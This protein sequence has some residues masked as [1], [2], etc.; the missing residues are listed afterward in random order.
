MLFAKRYQEATTFLTDIQQPIG[1]DNAKVELDNMLFLWP[2]HRLAKGQS[3]QINDNSYAGAVWR[4]NG[5]NKNEEKTL[6]FAMVM[7]EH[8]S[9]YFSSLFTQDIQGEGRMAIELLVND[10]RAAANANQNNPYMITSMDGDDSMIH[11]VK[12]IWEQQEQ[13][14]ANSPVFDMNSRFAVWSYT[15]EASRKEDMEALTKTALPKQ[16]EGYSLRQATYIELPH[17]MNWV[18]DYFLYYKDYFPSDHFVKELEKLVFTRCTEQLLLGNIYFFCD[19]IHKEGGGLPVSMIWQHIPL[20]HGTSIGY[21]Y[22]PPESRKQGLGGAMVSAF[23]LELLKKYKYINITVEGKQNPTDNM[24]TR[25]GFRF[26]GTRYC[27]RRIPNNNN[28]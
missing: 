21:V 26:E 17:L 28:N 9:V 25:L 3:N 14:T 4:Y 6:V 19:P 22:T 23:C 27:Y 13:Q 1:G 8:D 16:Q 10:I 5:D 20:S 11:L 12:E 18:T 24:Y 15:V 7:R 2:V